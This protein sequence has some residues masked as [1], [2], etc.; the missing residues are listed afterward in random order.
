MANFEYGTDI[1]QDRNKFFCKYCGKPLT[2]TER[3]SYCSNCGA[4]YV[5]EKEDNIAAKSVNVDKPVQKL[6]MVFNK[7]YSILVVV[8]Y[9][10]ACMFTV[11]TTYKWLAY[12]VGV[13]ESFSPIK[14][15][16][17]LSSI[18]ISLIVV[19]IAL[20]SL[21]DLQIGFK[22]MMTANKLKIFFGTLGLMACICFVVWIFEKS[23]TTPDFIVLFIKYLPY[24][25]SAEIISLYY[26]IW[27]PLIAKYYKKRIE[28]E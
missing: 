10:L 25:A 13:F 19:V 20:F 18:E 14:F 27:G 26:V 17:L 3:T 16:L 23:G 9:G 8:F 11:L 1:H 15:L 21:R 7:I 22:A 6:P 2:E 5:K 12:S 24:I 28:K 4:S